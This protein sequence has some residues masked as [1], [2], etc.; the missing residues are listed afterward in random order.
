M[1]EVTAAFEVAKEGVGLLQTM[2]ELVDIVRAP[3]ITIKGWN[4]TALAS[5][6]LRITSLDLSITGVCMAAT[7]VVTM[8]FPFL[9]RRNARHPIT[10]RRHG[11]H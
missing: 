9:Q 10:T 5:L 1:A 7:L 6:S 2:K 8:S 3:S 11:Q 4:E